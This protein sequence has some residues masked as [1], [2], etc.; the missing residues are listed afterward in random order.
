MF[1]L[2]TVKL[3]NLINS[4]AYKP[5]SLPVHQLTLYSAHGSRRKAQGVFVLLTAYGAR[6]TAYGIRHTA[7]YLATRG[8]SVGSHTSLSR[9]IKMG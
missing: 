6:Y 5:T 2:G 7:F 1:L 3:R 9:F 8:H 4:P